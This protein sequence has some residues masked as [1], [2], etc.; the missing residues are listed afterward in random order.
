MWSLCDT[1]CWSHSWGRSSF[2]SWG[3]I[4]RSTSWESHYS[5]RAASVVDEPIEANI[6]GVMSIIKKK[7]SPR[8]RLSPCRFNRR[9]KKGLLPRFSF[10]WLSLDYWGWIQ[11]WRDICSLHYFHSLCRGTISYSRLFISHTY[12]GQPSCPSCHHSISDYG[13]LWTLHRLLPPNVWSGR[14]NGIRQWGE[15]CSFLSPPTLIGRSYLNDLEYDKTQVSGNHPSLSSLGSSAILSSDWLWWRDWEALVGVDLLSTYEDKTRF[16]FLCC[17][18][19]YECAASSSAGQPFD[20]FSLIPFFRSKNGFGQPSRF[21]SSTSL[22]L[23]RQTPLPPPVLRWNYPPHRMLSL[24][25]EQLHSAVLQLFR[26]SL[27][28]MP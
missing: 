8:C 5:S 10:F 27:L 21:Y 17:L 7:S 18:Y 2:I 6:S 28:E 4:I 22:S 25:S 14:K 9:G 15:R 3:T 20:T 11:E 26:G 1:N 19:S 12:Q 23:K 13:E 24:K 16:G